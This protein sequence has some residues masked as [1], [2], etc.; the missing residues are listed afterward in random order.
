MPR[1]ACWC[2]SSLNSITTESRR[3][4]VRDLAIRAQRAEV[5]HG[6]PLEDR[7][8]LMVRV[9]RY[10]GRAGDDTVD[11][12]GVPVAPV[13]VR[14][15]EIAESRPVPEDRALEI[16]RAQ[17]PSRDPAA[18]VDGGGSRLRTVRPGRKRADIR[19]ADVA[20]EGPLLVESGPRV[21]RERY[22]QRI[23]DAVRHLDGAAVV[24][25]APL[26]GAPA[27]V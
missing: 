21:R 22:G 27:R 8:M 26:R 23:V 3:Q 24:A 11:V 25:P 13:A 5:L 20:P 15:T 18:L 2:D 10:G 14:G 6:A 7:G 19:L 1:W 4:P 9:I 16:L 17:G 12:D